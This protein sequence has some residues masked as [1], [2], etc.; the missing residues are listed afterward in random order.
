MTQ[1]CLMF[2]SYRNFNDQDAN[3]RIGGKMT[4]SETSA[5]NKDSIGKWNRGHSCDIDADII[6]L[7]FDN[8]LKI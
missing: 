8:V 4:V 1:H 3:K 7:Y 6:C 2:D 5:G